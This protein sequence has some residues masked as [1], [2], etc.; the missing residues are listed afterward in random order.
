MIFYMFKTPYFYTFL[1]CFLLRK[2]KNI[3]NGNTNGVQLV[4]IKAKGGRIRLCERSEYIFE[5]EC[6]HLL[7]R[8]TGSN[9][10]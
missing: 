7:A 9:A 1:G 5:R 8:N 3:E 6:L 4:L 10:R 2:E